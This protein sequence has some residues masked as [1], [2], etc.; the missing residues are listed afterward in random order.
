MTYSMLRN[1]KVFPIKEQGKDVPS[2]YSFS[3]MVEV[4]VIVTRSM[5]T[6]KGGGETSQMM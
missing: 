6:E 3:F 4:L 1:L 5:L 2:W